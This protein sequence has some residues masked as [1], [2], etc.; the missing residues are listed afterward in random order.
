MRYVITALVCNDNDQIVIDSEE[1]LVVNSPSEVLDHIASSERT[2]V[3]FDLSMV[4]GDEDGISHLAQI[5]A[6]IDNLL[7]KFDGLKP[8]TISSPWAG[9][10]N[11]G[12]IDWVILPLAA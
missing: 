11:E 12:G 10:A 8:V 3:G 7:I 6:S 9:P 1:A 4:D 2:E 5:R